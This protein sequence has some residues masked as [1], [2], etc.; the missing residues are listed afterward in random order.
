MALYG[1]HDELPPEIADEV[2]VDEKP[3]TEA[4]ADE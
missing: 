3:E 4:E 2:L 1:V